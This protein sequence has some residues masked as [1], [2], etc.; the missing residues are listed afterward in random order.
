MEHTKPVLISTKEKL[1]ERLVDFVGETP[2]FVYDGWGV[3]RPA[4]ISYVAD[5]ARGHLIIG[6]EPQEEREL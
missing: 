1:R 3:K 6:P 4:F 5:Q 2:I